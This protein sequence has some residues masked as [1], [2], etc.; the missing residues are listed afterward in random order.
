MLLCLSAG[1]RKTFYTTSLLNLISLSINANYN[2]LKLSKICVQI[3]A[4]DIYFPIEKTALKNSFWFKI[5]GQNSEQMLF[6]S[7]IFKAI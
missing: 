1:I 2:V 7:I 6:I 5:Y 3:K 4:Q